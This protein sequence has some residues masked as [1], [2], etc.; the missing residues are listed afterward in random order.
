VRYIC[1]LAYIGPHA[2]QGLV[3]AVRSR[4]IKSAKMKVGTGMTEL[5]VV[6]IASLKAKLARS[7][8]V[9]VSVTVS[10]KT[11]GNLWT[12]TKAIA[13]LLRRM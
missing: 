8:K 4:R 11:A 6:P 5:P 1:H 10:F 9:T 3:G 13:L 7:G 12:K 2:G